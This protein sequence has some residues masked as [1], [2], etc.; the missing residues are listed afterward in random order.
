MLVRNCVVMIH[1]LLSCFVLNY[2]V[3]LCSSFSTKKKKIEILMEFILFFKKKF[4]HSTLGLRWA[5]L[6]RLA[7]HS[8]YFFLVLLVKFLLAFYWWNSLLVE[9]FEFLTSNS[10]QIVYLWI[11]HRLRIINFITI[12]YVTR[13]PWCWHWYRSG[14]RS[15]HRL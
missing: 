10:Q 3:H 6:Q 7:H 4:F 9:I 8:L 2:C 5:N 13:C 15:C 1:H 14:N 11:L 12:S